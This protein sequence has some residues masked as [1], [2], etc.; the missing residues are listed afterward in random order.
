MSSLLGPKLLLSV[1]N[2]PLAERSTFIRNLRCVHFSSPWND[3]VYF[4]NKEYKDIQ[5]VSKCHLSVSKTL[6]PAIFS[7]TV[8]KTSFYLMVSTFVACLDMPFWWRS[9]AGFNLI[10]LNFPLLKLMDSQSPR[11]HNP[12]ILS[13]HFYARRNVTEIMTMWAT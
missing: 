4:N 3:C 12:L 6:R 11:T 10:A 1:L 13:V 2:F 5:K 7:S 9:L 8:Q